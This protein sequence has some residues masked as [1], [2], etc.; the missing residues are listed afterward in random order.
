M[1]EKRKEGDNAFLSQ[2][3]TVLSA[4]I[5]FETGNYVLEQLLAL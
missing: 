2:I 5:L 4:L 3:K 1:Y